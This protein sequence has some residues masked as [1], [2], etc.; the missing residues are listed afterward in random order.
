MESDLE[1]RLAEHGVSRAMWAVLC[2]VGFDGQSTPSA[3]SSFIGID[4]AA[5][6]RHV[7]RVVEMGLLSRETDPD[8]RRRIQLALTPRGQRLSRKLAAASKATN[9]KFT[10]GLRPAEVRALRE[11]IR[12]MLSNNDRV[13]DDI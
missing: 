1:G 5:V 4:R 2:A 11:A 13:I 7:D 10:K 12:T 3:L 8:D 9:E 6:T